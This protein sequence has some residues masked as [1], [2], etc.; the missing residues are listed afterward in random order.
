MLC[1]LNMVKVLS[2]ELN[3]GNIV[4][5]NNGMLTALKSPTNTRNFEQELFFDSKGRPGANP[6]PVT[7]IKVRKPDCGS[8]DTTVPGLCD[9]GNDMPDLD[10][11]LKPTITK[12]R[13]RKGRLSKDQFDQLCYAPNDRL[14]LDLQDA[15]IAILRDMNIDMIQ[16]AYP[17]QGLYA[18]GTSSTVAPKTINIINP[19]GH[20]NMAAFAVLRGEYRRQFFNGDPIVVSGE[21]GGYFQDIQQLGGTGQSLGAYNGTFPNWF[22]DNSMDATVQPLAGDTF[23]HTLTWAPGALQLLEWFQYKGYKAEEGKE[24]YVQTTLNLLGYEFDYT[25]RY[26]EC[27]SRW[28]W[29][30]SKQFDIFHIPDS[31]YDCINANNKLHFIMGCGDLA[32]AQWGL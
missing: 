30:L 12:A 8:T 2:P 20:V 16:A 27:N 1:C 23:S 7:E 6:L 13:S 18:D 19:L 31:A 11:Y 5:Q 28:D 15:A 26:D 22:Y 9:D 32:C 29:T 3:P 24:D 25:L 17:L 10:L 14:A 21:A 4:R